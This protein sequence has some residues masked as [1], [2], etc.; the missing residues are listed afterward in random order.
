MAVPEGVAGELDVVERWDYL[1][2]AAKAPVSEGMWATDPDGIAVLLFTSGTT[3]EP[4]GAVLRHHHLVSYII[5]TV[6]FLGAAENEA[7]LISVPPYHVA[8]ISAIL[9]SVYC[10]RRMVQI[11][12]FDPE[13]WTKVAR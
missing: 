2:A 10:G 1:A 12:A 5:S 8:G 13:R 7:A 6:E 4:K 3:G 9:S 11:E